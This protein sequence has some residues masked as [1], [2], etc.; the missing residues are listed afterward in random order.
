MALLGE[1]LGIAIEPPIGIGFIADVWRS[2]DL[3]AG[4]RAPFHGFLRAAFLATRFVV[5][6]VGWAGIVM[7]GMVIGMD[8][9]TDCPA[10]GKVNE[11]PRS[12]RR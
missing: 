4:L 6:A 5:L 2:P 7:P 8:C 1:G 11:A 10:M 3:G 12:N 9:A